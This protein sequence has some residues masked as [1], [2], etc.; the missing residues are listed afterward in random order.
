[1]SSSSL[2][3]F[4]IQIDSSDLTNDELD[5]MT[6]QF[7]TELRELDVESAELVKTGPAPAGAK[8]P[9]TIATGVIAVTMLPTLLPKILEG[10]HFWSIRRSNRNIKFK[11]KIGREAIEFEGSLKDLQEL[12]KTI[13]IAGK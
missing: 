2:A 8:S 12:L 13:K 7:L 6:R 11:G 5:Q 10:I 4:S 9:D 3:E 1:M